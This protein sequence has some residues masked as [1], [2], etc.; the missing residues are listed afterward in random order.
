MNMTPELSDGMSQRASCLAG[1]TDVFMHQAITGRI[2]LQVCEIRP[3][4]PDNSLDFALSASAACPPKFDW[5]PD[6]AWRL[7]KGL[8]LA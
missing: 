8:L 2:L 5:T 6:L 1:L 4:S 3:G 7:W